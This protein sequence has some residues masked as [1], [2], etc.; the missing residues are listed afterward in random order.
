MPSALR[1]NEK[2]TAIFTKE[3]TET[4]MK[5]SKPNKPTP[6]KRS[7]ETVR[8]STS[9]TLRWARLV[10]N[11]MGGRK[12][13]RLASRLLLS[14]SQPQDAEAH[15][16]AQL[17]ELSEGEGV[18]AAFGDHAIQRNAGHF[19]HRTRSNIRQGRDG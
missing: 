12:P 7:D 6:N 3:V 19:D 13:T 17:D 10:Q 5:G 2:T 8:P 11:S 15:A 16:T 14:L 4:A 9:L 1:T 18:P